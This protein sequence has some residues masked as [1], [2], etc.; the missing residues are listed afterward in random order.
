MVDDTISDFEFISE[1]FNKYVGFF[2]KPENKI[3]LLGEIW[4]LKL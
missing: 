1:L 4:P 3:L 2:A